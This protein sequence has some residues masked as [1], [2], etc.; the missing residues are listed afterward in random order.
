MSK[1]L[2]EAFAEL[3]TN[4][5]LAHRFVDDPQGVLD[6]LGVEEKNLEILAGPQAPRTRVAGVGR[7]KPPLKI[8]VSAGRDTCVTVGGHKDLAPSS[9]PI[10]GRSGPVPPPVSR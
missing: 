9:G 6:E 7:D 10:S 2:E 4:E 3:R 5:E 8:C 1:T